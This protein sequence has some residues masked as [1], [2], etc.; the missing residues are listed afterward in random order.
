MRSSIIACKSPLPF[1]QRSHFT[2]R[3][4]EL[5]LVLQ[6]PFEFNDGSGESNIEQNVS[7]VWVIYDIKQQRSHCSYQNNFQRYTSMYLYNVIDPP[8]QR[9]AQRAV[10]PVSFTVLR[11]ACLHLHA[12][13]PVQIKTIKHVFQMNRVPAVVGHV[14]EPGEQQRTTENNRE[15]Q[16]TTENNREQQRTT[17][18]NEQ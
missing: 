3:Q 11:N 13:L 18:N 5:N 16:R 4:I 6:Q 10:P 1:G 2:V 9:V 15:Q 12:A 8:A 14:F 7:I 17:E